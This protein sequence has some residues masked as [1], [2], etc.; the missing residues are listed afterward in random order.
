[1]KIRNVTLDTHVNVYHKGQVISHSFW[2]G[3][4]RK[5]AGI[6]F[7]GS[8]KFMTTCREEMRVTSGF[9]SVFWKNNSGSYGSGHSFRVPA[10]TTFKIVCD[11]VTEYVCIYG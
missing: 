8:Y 5:S 11:S 4:K 1:M 9:L 3:G 7:P 10:N 6:I 2:V